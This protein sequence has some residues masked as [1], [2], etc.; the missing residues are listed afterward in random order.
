MPGFSNPSSY[1]NPILLR[2]AAGEAPVLRVHARYDCDLGVAISGRIQGRFLNIS[3]GGAFLACRGELKIKDSYDFR[4]AGS[5]LALIGRVARIHVPERESP[6][7]RYYGVAFTVNGSQQEFLKAEVE[8][9]RRRGV[10]SSG[11][12]EKIARYWGS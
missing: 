2:R 6:G 11:N 1:H 9:A 10:K 7:L 8:K 5:R 3:M 12:D 4:L